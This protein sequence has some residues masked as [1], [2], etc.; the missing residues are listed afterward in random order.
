[1]LRSLALLCCLGTSCALAAPTTFY[2][3]PGGSDAHSGR[4]PAVNAARTDGPFATLG[5]ARQA[6]RNLRERGP[7]AAPVN[8]QLRAGQYCLDETLSFGPQD[9][10]TAERPVTYG[11]YRGERVQV[12]GG[13]RISGLKPSGGGRYSVLLPQVKSGAWSFKSLFIDGK[14]MVRARTPNV[15]PSD[16]YRKGFFYAGRDR[17]AFGLSVGCIHNVGDWMEYEIE[18]PADGQYALWT[19]YGAL[20]KPFGNDKMD[21]RTAMRVDGGTPVLLRDLPDTGGWGTYRWGNSAVLPLT[22]G[23]HVLH[24]ENLKGGGLDLEAFALSDDPALKLVNTELPA[25]AAGKHLLLIQAENFVRYQGKQLTT[26]GS[27]SGS[28]D[29]FHYAEGELRPEWA[30]APEVEVHIFQTSNCRAFKEIGLLRGLDPTTRKVSLGGSELSSFLLPGDRYFVENLP[31]AVDA[32]GE[33][34]LDR[35]RGL[36]TIL[37]PPGF[38]AKSEVIAP[39]VGRVIEVKGG[40]QPE[41]AVTGLR[42]VGLAIR[43][44]DHAATDGCGGYGMGNNGVVYLENCRACEVSGCTFVNIGKDAVCLHGGGG[45][46]VDGNDISDSAEGG[47]NVDGSSGNRLRGNHIHHCGQVYKHNGG[48]CLQNKAAGNLVH[49]NIV[50]D[51]TRYGI[52]MKLAGHNNVIEYNRVLNT[53]LETYDTGAIEVTQQDREDRSGSEIHHN[54]VGDTIGY[55]STDGRPYFLSWGIYLDSFAGGYTVHDNIVYRNQHGGIMFQGGKDNHVYNNIFVDGWLGQG[56]ISNFADNQT[57]CTL[58][59]NV[60]CFS[61]PGAYLFASPALTARTIAV[62]RN[63]YFCPGAKEYHTGWS[64]RSFKDWQAAGFDVHSVIADPLFVDRARDN[65]ALQPA[66]PAFKLGFREIDMKG[67][68]QCRCRIVPL[69]AVYF[70]NKPW[71]AGYR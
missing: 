36:L 62:D 4:L 3:A 14:R 37:P 42:F 70:D 49:G 61:N 26:G 30:Q 29:V 31:D 40:E 13:R 65:Y 25:P 32:P 11:A 2:V 19:Y 28:K 66:S 1:M 38:T 27:G 33:W 68:P 46:T 50:H 51:M 23:K 39:T 63:L 64:Q 53:N 9:G 6:V 8:V 5:R 16:P 44:G 54:L 15:D 34:Y 56:H 67:L 22:A 57:G 21:D 60:I 45:N 7:L 41:Q 10:G 59:R 18:V 35:A 58:E 47:L 12:V 48:I 52:T 43:G 69:A 17:N 24:W 71:P 20:N 55:S